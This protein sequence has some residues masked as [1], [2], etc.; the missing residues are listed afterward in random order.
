MYMHSKFTALSAL[1]SG[2]GEDMVNTGQGV[3][4]TQQ[5]AINCGGTP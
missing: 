5:A 1:W 2:R 3:F 4:Q